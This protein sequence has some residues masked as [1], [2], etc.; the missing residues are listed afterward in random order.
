MH[1][2]GAGRGHFQHFVIGDFGKFAGV[3]DDPRIA[4]VNA[5]HIGEDLANIGLERG[6]D[7]DGGE[8]G[9]AT[10]ERVDHAVRGDTLETGD[11]EGFPLI[12]ESAHQGGIHVEDAAAGVGAGGVDARLAAGD[13][14]GVHTLLLEGH[15]D[16]CDRLLLA[17]GQQ[18][19]E[20]ALARVFRK[21]L[22]HLDETIGDAGHRGN[23]G[24]NLIALVAGAF[25]PGGDIADSVESADGGAAV[26][27]NDEGHG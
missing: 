6:G 24:D 10:A 12:K 19:I 11:N 27:L 16:E 21:L 20:F 4:S 15:G 18:H 14:G 1:D 8:V 17:G 3:F 22:G 7:G 2:F 23:H 26:F 5:I 13:G 9:T 25:H